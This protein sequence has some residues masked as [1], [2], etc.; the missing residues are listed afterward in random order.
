[1][2]HER[3]FKNVIYT[4]SLFEINSFLCKTFITNRPDRLNP[5]APKLM[6][7]R[8]IYWAFIMY[9]DVCISISSIPQYVSSPC[10][11]L[12]PPLP[13]FP[14][15]NFL[16]RSPPPPPLLGVCVLIYLLHQIYFEWRGGR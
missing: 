4:N 10:L 6:D 3:K 16:L 1:M 8:I 14:P 15:H 2:Y 5:R 12:P 11:P 7:E 13:L 9:N